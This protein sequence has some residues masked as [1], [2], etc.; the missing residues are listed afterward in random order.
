MAQI[1]RMAE[2]EIAVQ[3]DDHPSLFKI[4][5]R[6]DLQRIVLRV[7]QRVPVPWLVL[8]PFCLRILFE[9]GVQLRRQRGRGHRFRQD[10]QARAPFRPLF[11]QRGHEVG[12][13][14][15]PRADFPAPPHGARA[16]GIIKLQDGCLMEHAGRAQAHGVIRVAF[17]LRGPALV[18][19]D[20]QSRR[21][22]TQRHRRGVSQRDAGNQFFRLFDVRQNL[23]DRLARA[24]RHPGQRERRRH[25]LE[26]LTPVRR[27]GP[28]GRSPWKFPVQPLV[29][30]RRGGH[31]LQPAPELRP[32]RRSQPSAH[33]REVEPGGR[34]ED[35]NGGGFVHRW[36]VAQSVSTPEDWTW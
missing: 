6:F 14:L 15:F 31:L 28:F 24:G 26:K 19:F 11:R 13:K 12:Q 18:A 34:G 5:I 36:Q 2:K 8:V 20:Q 29:E 3:R 33:R 1:G 10:A 27:V 21:V 22:A 9:E 25:D 32:L 7:P 4:V 23:L 17:D 35:G 16:V 30:L